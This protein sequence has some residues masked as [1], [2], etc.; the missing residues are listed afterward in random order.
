MENFT[1]AINVWVIT[2][3]SVGGWR[4]SLDSFTL[5][6]IEWFCPIDHIFSKGIGH[7][8]GS[9]IV[10]V[11]NFVLIQYLFVLVLFIFKFSP[12]FKELY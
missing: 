1:Y 4:F 10:K 2:V 5:Y 7:I 6:L 11:L 8:V 9:R 3:E 12:S